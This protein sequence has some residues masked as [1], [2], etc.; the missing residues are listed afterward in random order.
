MLTIESIKENRY[1]IFECISG[2]KAYGLDTP[3]SD[4]DIR[5]V[6]ILPKNEF[7]SLDYVGQVNN[8][9]NDICFYE[10]KKFIELLFKN[11]PNI[12]EMLYTDKEFILY[13]HSIF[14][15]I[16]PEYFLSKLCKETFAGYAMTQMKK[17]KGLNKKIF[18]PFSEERKNLI[19][20]CFVPE[21]NG[22]ICLDHWL[23]ENNILQENCGLTNIPHMRDSYYLY[24]DTER[25]HGF[26]G[27]LS[28][29]D[30]NEVML[31]SIPKG[32]LPFSYFYF[33]KDE[34]SRYCK[35]Y[36]EYWD[37]VKFRNEDRYR[38]TVS[39]NKNYDAKNMMH[40]FR[41]LEMAEEILK[42]NKIT[43]KR[44]NPEELLKI[45]NG[46]YSYDELVVKANEKLLNIE[47]LAEKS[48]LPDRPEKELADNLLINIRDTW[49]KLK[50]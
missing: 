19:S 2:S 29:E 24:Y 31:S 44:K 3:S 30:S 8:A 13:K 23:I 1:L 28:S 37:W 18:K 4:T 47:R 22:S 43:L 20:F 41:L 7:Y 9:T 5:G 32:L 25:K 12:L 39:Q 10:I 27:I 42:D 46:F 26:R 14:D 33:N 36:R 34:Y 50:N 16:K 48:S 40:T 15:N 49:Y 45:K 35:E 6:F 21:K 11:N 17:A 38:N